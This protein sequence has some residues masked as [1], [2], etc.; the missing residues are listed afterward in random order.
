[1]RGDSRSLLLLAAA[2][3]FVA[4]QIPYG[5]YVL[6]PFTVLAVYAHEMGHGLT[7]MLVGAD[8]L[9]L[10]LFVNGGLATWRGDVGRLGQALIAAGGLIGPSLAGAGLLMVSRRAARA[11]IILAVLGGLIGLSTVLFASGAFA[12]LFT[13]LTAT[14]CLAVARKA[15]KAAPFV[16]QLLGVQLCIAL[17]R[18]V[19]Y[20]FSEGGTLGGVQHASDTA[21]IAEALFLPYWFWGG[22]IAATSFAILVGGL[23][24]ALRPLP[25]PAS[26]A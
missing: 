7:A 12:L 11:P 6:Y 17:F 24:R 18:D 20:M 13:A 16:L 5:G 25:T 3:T 26:R 2:V 15:P 8:F 14:A 21:A 19:H 1:M 22:L 23:Y 9:K 10:E 4:W